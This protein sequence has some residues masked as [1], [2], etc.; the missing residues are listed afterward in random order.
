MKE[1]LI[2]QIILICIIQIEIILYFNKI[3][4]RNPL[5]DVGFIYFFLL[6]SYIFFPGIG[7]ILAANGDEFF[8]IAL[9]NPSLEELYKHQWRQIV[10]YILSFIGFLIIRSKIKFKGKEGKVNRLKNKNTTV[11]VIVA[12]II[13]FIILL[14]LLSAPVD[15]Y[16]EGYT[17][18][19]HLNYIARRILSVVINLKF[20]FYAIALV[21][22]FQNYTRYKSSILI[23]TTIICLFEI[24]YSY[25]SRI[26]S[27]KILLMVSCLYSVYV[28][29]IKIMKI[30]MILFALLIIFSMV[31][32]V[33][34]A[35]INDS[36]FITYLIEVGAKPAEEFGALFFTGFKL[37]E[38]RVNNGL[39]ETNPLMF[40]YDLL[41]IIPFANFDEVNP[42]VW[43]ARN[44]YPNAVVPPFTLGPI[45]VS[46]IYGGEIDLG[47]R[48]FIL[49]LIIASIS[50][51]Y[52]R[53]LKSWIVASIYVYF[54]STV[55]MLLKYDVFWF[56]SVFVKL[57][58]PSILVIYFIDLTLDKLRRVK[59][60][61]TK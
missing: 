17:R 45:A 38:L 53:N 33:R 3:T 28:R 29:K 2:F 22:F 37:Y 4:N 13:I 47:V 1:N 27:F 41:A 54:Y 9:G 36:D 46:A 19:D 10:F 14:E 35:M 48:G 61:E 8:K 24:L 5:S 49:G 31:E 44:F 42:I 30:V 23:F 59:S 52:N 57:L 34:S 26:E 16:Y 15:N 39:P 18:Y 25:G 40:L 6:F 7:I 11:K 51:W 50:N 20:G 32:L 21:I 58:V 55:V 60:F 56:A 43:Y 12:A